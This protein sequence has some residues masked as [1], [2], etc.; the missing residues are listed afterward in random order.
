MTTRTP[1]PLLARFGANVPEAWRRRAKMLDRYFE[2]V[3]NPILRR[4]AIVTP[5]P[6]YLEFNGTGYPGWHYVATVERNTGAYCELDEQFLHDY[7]HSACE[8]AARPTRLK[9]QAW[10]RNHMK[11]AADVR[12]AE[13]LA[14]AKDAAGEMMEERIG[15]Y[16]VRRSRAVRGVGA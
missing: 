14:L 6:G 15:P 4:W 13:T 9:R 5:G 16:A 10:L 11:A 12:R 2:V 8:Q 1:P 7:R 3:W